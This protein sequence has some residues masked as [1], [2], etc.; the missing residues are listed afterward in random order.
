MLKF[1]GDALRHLF[2]YGPKAG[3]C[4]RQHVKHWEAIKMSENARKLIC[5]KCGTRWAMHDGLRTLFVLDA[6]TENE[7]DQV[8][9][10]MESINE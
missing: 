4:L 9:I 3:W 6:E 7:L 8:K 1:L 10:I 2:W 5:H